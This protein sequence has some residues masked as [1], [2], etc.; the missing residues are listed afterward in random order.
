MITEEEKKELEKLI[1]EITDDAKSVV[2]DYINNPPTISGSA[3]IHI[4]EESPWLDENQE[5]IPLTKKR[6]KN[7]N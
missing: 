6:K 5:F 2:E 3:Q 1:K 4:H 7:V